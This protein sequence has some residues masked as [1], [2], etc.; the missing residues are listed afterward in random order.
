MWNKTHTVKLDYFL[1]WLC[2]VGFS[3]EQ[4][5]YNELC[6]WI[7][8]LTRHYT[9]FKPFIIAS[10]FGTFEKKMRI[11]WKVTSLAL[12]WLCGLIVMF[13]SA[14]KTP[15]LYVPFFLT[16]FMFLFLFGV[17]LATLPLQICTSITQTKVV[18]TQ[19]KPWLKSCLFLCSILHRLL[20]TSCNWKI[21]CFAFDSSFTKWG[22][23]PKACM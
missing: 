13:F 17:S 19:V 11:V 6:I 21:Y 20:L 9:I 14:E 7:D 18:M 16:I 22:K 12:H 15:H 4:A 3:A 5:N 10:T 1:G 8:R 23:W 2:N